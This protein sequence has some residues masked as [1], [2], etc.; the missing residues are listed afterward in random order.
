M[1]SIPWVNN[2]RVLIQKSH[3]R[4]VNLQLFAESAQTLQAIE[5]LNESI[6]NS[7]SSGFS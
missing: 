2:G 3:L 4:C 1:E 5:S 6:R 7:R